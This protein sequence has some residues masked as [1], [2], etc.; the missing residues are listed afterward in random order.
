M[1]EKKYPENKLLETSILKATLE[2]I[3][4]LFNVTQKDQ[5]H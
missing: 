3:L 1:K 2:N 4:A 5:Q